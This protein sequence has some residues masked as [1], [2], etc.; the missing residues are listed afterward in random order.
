MVTEVTMVQD[1]AE[2]T[3]NM[4]QVPHDLEFGY[5]G[6]PGGILR[7]RRAGARGSRYNRWSR[8]THDRRRP[9]ARR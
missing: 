6:P 8:G 4:E 2:L 7:D 3:N 5:E 9:E 1:G